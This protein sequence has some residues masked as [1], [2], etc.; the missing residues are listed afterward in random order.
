MTLVRE[1]DGAVVKNPDRYLSGDRFRLFATVPGTAATPWD[2]AV[3]QEGEV[4]FPLT[5]EGAVEPG[6]D[7]PLPG[8]FRLTGAASTE[9]CLYTG[10]PLTD[11]DKIKHEGRK[12]LPETA[13]CR[14]LAPAKGE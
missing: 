4:F 11:R 2:V 8:A 3:F 9:I 5:P 10:S 12:A 7:V 6:S 13:V 14:T 1:R